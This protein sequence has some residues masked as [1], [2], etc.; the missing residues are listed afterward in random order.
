M[1]FHL[2]SLVLVFLISSCGS[3]GHNNFNKRKYLKLK[4]NDDQSEE[5]VINENEEEE[6]FLEF[7]NQFDYLP[8]EGEVEK[9]ESSGK[10]VRSNVE[11]VLDQ[12]LDVELDEKETI[13][14]NYESKGLSLQVNEDDCGDIITLRT[15]EK[16]VAKTLEVG[17]DV[18][19]YKSCSNLDGP[20]YSIEKSK[21]SMIEY[22]NGDKVEF[23]LENESGNGTEVNTAAMVGF[24][25]LCLGFITVF[26]FLLAPIFG[27]IGLSQMKK[28]P[29][30]YKDKWMAQLATIFGLLATVILVI[31]FVA[32][33]MW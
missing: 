24:V 31:L 33:L 30:R 13:I 19:R 22:L 9:T 23:T 28:E 10:I 6:E 7:E 17:T 12:V 8:F 18:I 16:I 2:F 27:G 5:L 25:M 3:I 26:S 4:A 32:L 29:N 1:K 11:F 15:G 21:V 20:T 14:T